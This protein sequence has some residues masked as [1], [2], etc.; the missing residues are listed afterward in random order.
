MKYTA[1]QKRLLEDQG[2]QFKFSNHAMGRTGLSRGPNKRF[3]GVTKK[4]E[5]LGIKPGKKRV[6]PTKV[7]NEDFHDE[8]L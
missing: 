4:D 3:K 6:I 2:T 1:A 7:D 5:K 8:D